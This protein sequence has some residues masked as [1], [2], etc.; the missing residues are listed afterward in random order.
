MVRIRV[1][2]N[3]SGKVIKGKKNVVKD[4]DATSNIGLENQEY[5]VPLR[6]I[7]ACGK[8]LNP[9]STM[10]EGPLQLFDEGAI[11]NK[12]QV[13]SPKSVVDK[14][15]GD[16]EDAEN[17]MNGVQISPTKDDGGI[18]GDNISQPAGDSVNNLMGSVD[19]IVGESVNPPVIN[20][21]NIREECVNIT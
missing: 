11:I 9:D 13:E 15:L 16:N 17:V 18:V 12:T 1:G 14:D 4:T 19:N 21:M 2:I 3:T 10:S 7:A 6:V 5:P 8:E 20:T